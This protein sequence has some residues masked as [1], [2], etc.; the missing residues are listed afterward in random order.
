MDAPPARGGV[1]RVAQHKIAHAVD[2]RHPRRGLENI[3]GSFEV[4]GMSATALSTFVESL[5]GKAKALSAFATGS[6]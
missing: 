5:C 3:H 6:R 1:H 2:A 4:E